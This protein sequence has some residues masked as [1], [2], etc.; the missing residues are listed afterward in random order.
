MVVDGALHRGLEAGISLDD[1]LH[2]LRG[3]IVGRRWVLASDPHRQG[4]SSR[5]YSFHNGTWFF[6]ANSGGA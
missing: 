5:Y 2:D 4:R 3:Q 6:A 1:G